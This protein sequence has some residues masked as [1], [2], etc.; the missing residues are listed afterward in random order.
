MQIPPVKIVF[1]KEEREEILQRIDR[2]LLEGQ[3]A[4]GQN[5]REFE[6]S[7]SRYVGVKHAVAVSSGGAAIEVAMRL[8]GAKGHKVLVPTNTFAATATGVLLAGGCVRFVDAD[9]NTFSVSLASLQAAATSQ[10]AGVIVVHIGGIMTHEIEA[11]RAWCKGKGLWLFEDAAHAHGS[12]LNGKTPGQFGQVAAYSFFATKVMT[13]GEGGM[14]VTDD[15]GLAK[16]AKGLRD[17]GKPEPWVTL[18]TEIGSNWRMSEFCAAVGLVHLRRLEEFIAWRKKVADL[19]TA[20]LQA[21]PEIKPI[22]PGDKASWYKYILLLP[23]GVDRERVR[24]AMK[25]RGVHL[26]GGV[27][28]IPLHQ[29]PAFKAMAQGPYPVADDICSRHICLPLYYGMTDEEASFVVEC[30]RSTLKEEGVRT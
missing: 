8:L 24:T 3:V 10:T 23:T 6:A 5:V 25:N 12:S 30:L 14:L 16:R 4:Q 26:S 11:I 29:Q 9:P 21:V 20:Q 22:L 27:Y 19:Y 18:H 13:S 7:F 17:Y 2:C 15:D 1:S 28:D